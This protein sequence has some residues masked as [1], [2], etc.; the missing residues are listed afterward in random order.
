MNPVF[1]HITLLLFKLP[2]ACKNERGQTLTEYA[3]IILL[4]ALVV[5]I[6]LQTTGQNL[7]STY[8]SKIPAAFP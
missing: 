8:Y 2:L 4:I 5:F 1:A 6:A 3:L 7:S